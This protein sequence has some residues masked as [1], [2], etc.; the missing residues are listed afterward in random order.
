MPSTFAPTS[1]PPITSV[2]LAQMMKLKTT[3]THL[4][5]DTLDSD[6]DEE[7]FRSFLVMIGLG[8][9]GMAMPVCDHEESIS[10]HECE[11]NPDGDKNDYVCD[12]G[13]S[14][15][16]TLSATTVARHVHKAKAGQLVSILLFVMGSALYTVLAVWDYQWAKSVK[17]WPVE[18]L[19]N[20]EDEITYNKYRLE[21]LYYG[22][23]AAVETAKGGGR[24]RRI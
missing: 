13:A 15:G 4:P 18:V 14:H 8:Q 20:Y 24:L 11:D 5:E 6:S 12:K 19:M 1:P 2:V 7:S 10:I 21:L 22:S 9:C 17:G 23:V 3:E 16:D